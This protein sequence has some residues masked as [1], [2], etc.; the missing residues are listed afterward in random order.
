MRLIFLHERFCTCMASFE[1]LMYFHETCLKEACPDL[2]KQNSSRKSN[3]SH[4]QLTDSHEIIYPVKI[5]PKR[6]GFRTVFSLLLR[7]N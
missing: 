2:Y 1:N 3:Q 6:R 7:S 5:D 4:R